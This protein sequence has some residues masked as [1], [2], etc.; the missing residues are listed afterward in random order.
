MSYQKTYYNPNANANPNINPNASQSGQPSAR[1]NQEPYASNY[2]NA[3]NRNTRS[4]AGNQYN[5][6]TK[7][8]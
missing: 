1:I 5:P 2:Q 8:I 6:P 3:P 4:Q 7:N